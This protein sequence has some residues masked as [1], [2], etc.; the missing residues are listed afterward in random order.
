MG[1]I[2]QLRGLDVVEQDGIVA[3]KL[4]P[5]AGTVRLC[6]TRFVPLHEHLIAQGFLEFV[7]A[8]GKGPL[9]YNETRSASAS[10]DDPTKPKR[11]PF[12]T[13]RE[14]IAA[15]VRTIGVIDPEL[16]PNHAWRHTFK[17]IGFRCGI[18]ERTI[19]AIVGHAPASV[20][21]GYGAPTLADKSRELENFPRYQ[22]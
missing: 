3:M 18:T 12:V 22:T 14:N 11:P 4:S 13:A 10:P 17:A 9:F 2:T 19:D 7:K 6:D 21:R 16:Q 20:G 5:E 15:W 8:S 1:E